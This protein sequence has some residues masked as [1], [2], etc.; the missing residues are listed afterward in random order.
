MIVS[1]IIGDMAGTQFNVTHLYL[2]ME[3][4]SVL[5]YGKYIFK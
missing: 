3:K 1:N 4:I 5:L 2:L